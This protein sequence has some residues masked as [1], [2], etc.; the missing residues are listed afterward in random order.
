MKKRENDERGEREGKSREGSNKARNEMEKDRN[1]SKSI[2]NAVEYK[3]D[4]Y[5]KK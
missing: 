1:Q 2:V 4:R 3:N 5:G